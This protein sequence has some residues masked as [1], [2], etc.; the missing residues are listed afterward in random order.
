MESWRKYLKEQN[1]SFKCPRGMFVS[2]ILPPAKREIVIIQ[3]S[4]GP[5]AFYRSTGSGTPGRNTEDMWLP[6]GGVGQNNGDPWIMKLPSGH[7]QAEKS[8]F[9]K[10]GSEFWNIG[11][12]LARCYNKSPFSAKDWTEYLTKFKFPSYEQV[13][14]YAGVGRITYGAM[15]VNHWLNSKGALKV[16]WRSEG[17]YGSTKHP[18]SGVGKISG[19][20]TDLAGLS[21]RGIHNIVWKNYQ[22]QGKA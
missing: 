7:S 2:V 4:E 16:D 8:K 22:K 17:I 3:T 19:H 9:P 10:K 15:V 12:E 18:V 11:Q 20:S 13:E 6:M 21:L 1:S 5:V 14:Q